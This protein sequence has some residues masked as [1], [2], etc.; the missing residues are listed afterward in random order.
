M[1]PM[2]AH[3][4]RR[5]SIDGF[6]L[7]ELLVLV[8]IVGILSALA[9]PNLLGYFSRTQVDAGAEA[10]EGVLRQA[11]RE[12]IRRSQT[13]AVVIPT[14]ANPVV[15]TATNTEVAGSNENCLPA[16]NLS[17]QTGSGQQAADLTLRNIR[18]DSNLTANPPTVGFTFKGT[19]TNVA[20]NT[21]LV[22]SSTRSPTS[23]R[24]CIVVSDLLG[25]I[26]AG[27]YNG[28]P[29]NPT[30]ANCRIRPQ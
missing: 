20:A 1:R 22:I 7:T 4:P 16:R 10:L 26:R 9:V 17:Q 3:L 13:C 6:T 21:V 27:N 5:Q 25:L 14:G 24:R 15:R 12:A 30:E 19:P 18:I 23:G 8:I 2:N 29:T 11:Q 28:T